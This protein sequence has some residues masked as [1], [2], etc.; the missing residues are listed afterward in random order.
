MSPVAFG[1]TAQGRGMQSRPVIA[2]RKKPFWKKKQNKTGLLFPWRVGKRRVGLLVTPMLSFTSYELTSHSLLEP[3][4]LAQNIL[5]R[6][7]WRGPLRL[8]SA[9][10]H[11]RVCVC[12]YA[13]ARVCGSVFVFPPSFFLSTHSLYILCI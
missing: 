2:H 1:Q 7:Q 4:N 3:L 10:V 6:G 11:A 5:A 13:C 9:Q 12:V 8:E